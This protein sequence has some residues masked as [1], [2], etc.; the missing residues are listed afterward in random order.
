MHSSEIFQKALGQDLSLLCFP[1]WHRALI[2]PWL[3]WDN[4]SRLVELWIW[5]E[6][7]RR[8]GGGAKKLRKREKVDSGRQEA[9]QTEGKNRLWE[10][11]P[12]EEDSQESAFLPGDGNCRQEG[13]G[14]PLGN[15]SWGREDLVGYFPGG[16][17]G[18]A[19][20]VEGGFILAAVGISWLVG[21]GIWTKI[22]WNIFDAL[23]GAVLSLPLFGG[24]WLGVN[25][26]WGP[27]GGLVRLL[28]EFIVPIFRRC[29]VWQ[30]GFISLLAGLGE[31]MFFRGLMQD[32]L[33]AWLG[34]SMGLRETLGSCLAVVVTSAV[35]GLLHG[36]S[37]F[38]V[39]LAGLIGAYL[40]WW[41]IVTGNLLGPIVAHAVYDFAALVYLTKW[42]PAAAKNC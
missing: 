22:H 3:I 38:Y 7:E 8:P 19:V 28:A 17:L 24:L 10:R 1:S 4:Q 32:G 14:E 34:S 11:L 18:I 5:R 16:L 15:Q 6:K 20:V 2:I 27:W 12:P 35:F 37:A 29:T 9:R 40:G 41:R 13:P 31:E 39:L 42:W 26:P 23:W 21:E 30:L 36:I 33:T 25:Y